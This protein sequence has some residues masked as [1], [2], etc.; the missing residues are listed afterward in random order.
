[1]PTDN[2]LDGTDRIDDTEIVPRDE[3]EQ[4]GDIEGVP[5]YGCPRCDYQWITEDCDCPEC[6]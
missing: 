2:S 3:L 1:M 5:V 4:T 6:G